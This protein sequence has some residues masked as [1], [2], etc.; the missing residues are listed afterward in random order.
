MNL[1]EWASR[2]GL[3]PQALVELSGALSV[4]APEL[5]TGK[6]ESAVQSRV[7]LA[8]ARK[9][10][11]HLWRN[12]VGVLVDKTGRPV[13]Y[14]LANDSK[15]VNEVIKSA[16]LIGLE[17]VLITPAH[18]GTIIGRFV[19]LECKPEGW[20]YTATP[21]EVAQARWANLINTYGGSARFINSEG[22]L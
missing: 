11:M 3:P 6:S 9:G 4:E 15:A 14:G 22:S 7:R 21:R 2:W 17:K 12:N 5:S 16:D 13:R 18:I 8:A 1:T 19:S 10:T 20:K